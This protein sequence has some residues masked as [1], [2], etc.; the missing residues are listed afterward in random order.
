VTGKKLGEMLWGK[1]SV[2]DVLILQN[3]TKK[4]ILYVVVHIDAHTTERTNKN[5]QLTSH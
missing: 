4:Q 2:C 3:Q 5:E 1:K